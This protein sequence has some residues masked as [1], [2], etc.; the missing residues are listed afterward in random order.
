MKIKGTALARAA[1][2][3]LPFLNKELKKGNLV[4]DEQK[5][6]DLEDFTNRDWLVRRGGNP[7]DINQ[8]EKIPVKPKIKPPV[9]V[10]I[11]EK[12]NDS[13]PTLP[14]IEIDSN[15]GNFDIVSGIPEKMLDMTIRELVL[16]Y[17][18]N[19]GLKSYVDILDKLMSAR[20]KDL[21][22][23]EI[24]KDLVPK[25][26]ILHLKSFVDNFV[27]LLFDYA[28]TLPLTI[29]PLVQADPE[30]AKKEI[31]EKLISNF[32]KFADQTKRQMTRE[33]NK[34]NNKKEKEHV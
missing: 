34:L 31:P 25:D 18:G 9:S 12:N 13:L 32:S 22:I 29:I 23:Q 8:V 20:T 1:G 28:E 6:Y 10:E 21:K 16:Q 33:I 7:D 3:K 17:Q 4:R 14:E 24:R 15:S 26:F 5:F 11:P 30:K 19:T 27:E 2:V